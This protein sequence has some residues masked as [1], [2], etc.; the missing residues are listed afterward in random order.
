M[1]IDALLAAEPYLHIA[2]RVFDPEKFVL[3]TDNIMNQIEAST[4]PVRGDTVFASPIPL[5]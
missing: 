5:C 2:E 4:E 3:L 1:L